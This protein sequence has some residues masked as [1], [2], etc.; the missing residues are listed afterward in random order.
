M[1]CLGAKLQ[2]AMHRFGIQ[3]AALRLTCFFSVKKQDREE[4][5]V[6]VQGLRNVLVFYSIC[7]DFTLCCTI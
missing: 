7:V 1:H 4:H 2:V 3:I 6:H 5:F